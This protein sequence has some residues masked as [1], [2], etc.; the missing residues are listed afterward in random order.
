M[1]GQNRIEGFENLDK[2][3]R[4]ISRP[5][6]FCEKAIA[7]AA[8]ILLESTKDSV[9]KAIYQP[10]TA[11]KGE[12]ERTG[13][14]ERSFMASKPKTNQYGSFSSIQPVGSR[15]DKTSGGKPLHYAAQA[16]FLEW[17][18]NNGQAPSPF[19]HRAVK[20][21]EAK[22]AETMEKTFLREISKHWPVEYD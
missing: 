9:H 19:R 13:A 17:G 16:A 3:F 22:C 1:S 7:E 2:L 4:E 10:A 8:P 5:Q 12:P 18:T 15:S 14:L 6:E 20:N 11:R 21:A